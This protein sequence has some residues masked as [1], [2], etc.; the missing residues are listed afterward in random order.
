MRVEIDMEMDII[1]KKK[2]NVWRVKTINR[3]L[4]ADTTSVYYIIYINN[5]NNSQCRV[6]ICCLCMNILLAHIFDISILSSIIKKVVNLF[7]Q[8]VYKPIETCKLVFNVMVRL[9]QQGLYN[10]NNNISLMHWFCAFILYYLIIVKMSSNC[11]RH[12]VAY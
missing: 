6:I 9:R 4:S 8:T 1:Y 7:R 3:Y 10:D 2:S 12:D 5:N 11:T